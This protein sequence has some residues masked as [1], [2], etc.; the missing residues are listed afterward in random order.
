MAL[1]KKHIKGGHM[2]KGNLEQKTKEMY[3]KVQTKRRRE[4]MNGS[5]AEIPETV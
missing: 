1:H 5:G 3:Y 4:G 2:T